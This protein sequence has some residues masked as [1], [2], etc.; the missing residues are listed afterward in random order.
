MVLHQEVLEVHRVQEV[1]RAQEDHRAA[2]ALLDYPVHR[3]HL[4]H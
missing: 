2:R 1:H 4:R 3:V